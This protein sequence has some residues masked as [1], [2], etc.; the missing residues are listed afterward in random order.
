MIIDM[1]FP[2]TRRHSVPIISITGTNGK[3]TTARMI[4]HI[5]N[6]YGMNVD[7]CNWRYLYK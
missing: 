5:L 4:S 3:T 1:L 7:S 2:A 6:V